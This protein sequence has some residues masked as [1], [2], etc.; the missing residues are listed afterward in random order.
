MK[1]LFFDIE[2]ANNFRGVSKV[3]EFG[4][5]L[6]DEN[7]KIITKETLVMS[8]GKKGDVKFDRNIVKRDEEFNRAY[9]PEYYYSQPEY[10]AFY[11]KIKKMLED[12]E[13]LVFGY[14]IEND[15]RF[16]FSNTER[17]HLPLMKFTCYDV[18]K[19]AFLFFEDETHVISLKKAFLKLYSEDEFNKLSAHLSEDDALM[20]MRIFQKLAQNNDICANN[21]LKRAP[22]SVIIAHNYYQNYLKKKK[23]KE[24]KLASKT[25]SKKLWDEACKWSEKQEKKINNRKFAVTFSI[26]DNLETLKKVIEVIKKNNYTAVSSPIAANYII[27]LNEDDTKGVIARFKK[28]FNGKVI[29]FPQFLEQKL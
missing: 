13:T 17:Y 27:S 6:T 24:K 15:I 22:N 3:C 25:V 16:L 23:D 14:S 21:L 18:Q 5:V 10:P 9:T 29:S 1:Y 12:E 8:P 11:E 26:L 7:F 28:P 20:T 2:C 19:I 4:Y